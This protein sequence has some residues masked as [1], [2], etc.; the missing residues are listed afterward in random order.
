MEGAESRAPRPPYAPVSA[1]ECSLISVAPI[2]ILCKGKTVELPFDVSELPRLT[3]RDLKGDLERALKDRELVL[4]ALKLLRSY[5]L[6]RLVELDD[7]LVDCSS[8]RL[9]ELEMGKGIEYKGVLIGVVTEGTLISFVDVIEVIEEIPITPVTIFRKCVRSKELRYAKLEELVRRMNECIEKSGKP[10]YLSEYVALLISESVV[11]VK[12]GDSFVGLF[13]KRGKRLIPITDLNLIIKRIMLSD[14][15]ASYFTPTPLNLSTLQNALQI[16]SDALRMND[17]ESYVAFGNEV[18]DV[19][20]WVERG[21]LRKVNAKTPFYF[22]VSVDPYEVKEIVRSISSH[23]E[24]LVAASKRVPGLFELAR[25]VTEEDR[26]NFL[27]SFALIPYCKRGL[28]KVILL[29]GRS[30]S[31]KTLTLNLIETFAKDMVGYINLNRFTDYRREV[32]IVGLLGKLYALQDEVSPR[33][34]VANVD[35]LKSLTGCNYTI[36]WQLYKGNVRFKNRATIFLT[37]NDVEG[38]SE[39]LKLLPREEL[40]ALRSRI[41]PIRFEKPISGR[42]ASEIAEWVMENES[43]VL[44][45]AL[46]MGRVVYKLGWKSPDEEVKAK[47]LDALYDLIA[48]ER[49]TVLKRDE[50]R[51]CIPKSELRKVLT[52]AKVSRRG[53]EL[54]VM[55]YTSVKLGGRKKNVVCFYL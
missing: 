22:E 48:E 11:S 32:G 13:E 41:V 51:I 9:I 4:S 35:L 49:V 36:A 40:N 21:V 6:G 33:A 42:E 52:R 17:V 18:Y 50:E 30:L 34:L 15:Y 46:A 37:L 29:M 38:F 1:S 45:W 19:K 53:L 43:A 7:D 39:A 5:G 24:L 31:G 12:D 55:Y 16:Y 2:A 23:R 26:A 25:H 28:K 54:G 44:E 8:V 3:I 20:R 14:K 10:C 47:V 27:M